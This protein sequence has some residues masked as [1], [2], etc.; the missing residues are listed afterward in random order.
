MGATFHWLMSTTT[1][2]TVTQQRHEAT[3][4]PQR[5]SRSASFKAWL[6]IAQARHYIEA[7]RSPHLSRPNG[8]KVHS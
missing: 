8:R 4:N 6:V 7:T 2:Y 3:K 5:I 1:Y